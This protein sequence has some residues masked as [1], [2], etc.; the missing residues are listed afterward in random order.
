VAGSITGGAV[1]RELNLDHLLVPL[2]KQDDDL[3]RSVTCAWVMIV[4]RA[5]GSQM[6]R[7]WLS[8]GTVVRHAR[9]AQEL[10]HQVRIY[11]AE[12]WP[13]R[14]LTGWESAW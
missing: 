5:N 14:R 13:S 2:S 12:L 10:G 11:R 1:V 3:T 4:V 8:A 7:C 9:R 6:R